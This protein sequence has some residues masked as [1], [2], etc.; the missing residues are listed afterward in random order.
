MVSQSRH[1]RVFWNDDPGFVKHLTHIL[2]CEADTREA[3]GTHW[4]K[5]GPYSPK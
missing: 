2:L 1:A 5:S 4:P 3:H